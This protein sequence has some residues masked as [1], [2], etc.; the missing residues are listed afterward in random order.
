MNKVKLDL[1]RPSVLPTTGEF[2]LFNDI[3]CQKARE[4]FNHRQHQGTFGLMQLKGHMINKE[5]QHQE[6]CPALE[7]GALEELDELLNGD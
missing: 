7:P 2:T 3:T 5:V 6:G 1:N 4:V